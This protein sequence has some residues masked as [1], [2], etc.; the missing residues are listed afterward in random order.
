MIAVVQRVL[1]AGVFVDD[2]PYKETIGAG[3]C[4]L[5]GVEDGDGSNDAGWMAKKLSNLRIF[6][7]D[8]GKMNHSILDVQGELLLVSQFTLVADCSQGNRP[9]FIRASKP[10]IAEPLVKEVGILLQ[11]Y[12]VP[13]KTGLFGASMRVD[14][15]N[16]GPVTIVLKQD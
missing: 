5:L 14:I 7:D 4:V 12:G 11:Q 16:D 1:R 13:V 6:C 15:E 2:P 3:L 10:D 8:D 9:S